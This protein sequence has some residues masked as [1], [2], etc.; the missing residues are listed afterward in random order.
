M[1]L[2]EYVKRDGCN[3]PTLTFVIDLKKKKKYIN[4]CSSVNGKNMK[5]KKRTEKKKKVAKEYV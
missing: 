2:A 5:Q 4:F 3:T 1:L